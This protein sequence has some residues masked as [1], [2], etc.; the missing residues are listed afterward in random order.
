MSG[1]AQLEAQRER[2]GVRPPGSNLP[3]ACVGVAAA[4]MGGHVLVLA[5]AHGP[6]RW[7]RVVQVS[8]GVVTL[9]VAL[10]LLA[11]IVAGLIARRRYRVALELGEQPWRRPPGLIA[12]V[13]VA[14]ATGLIVYNGI[15]LISDLPIP[16]RQRQL[17]APPPPA[18]PPANP[19]GQPGLALSLPTRGSS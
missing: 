4:V 1:P 10:A 16:D 13:L 9:L 7:E 19:T 11:A 8:T 15:R 3:L 18:L 12:L 5:Y 6:S 14:G 17:P 2:P